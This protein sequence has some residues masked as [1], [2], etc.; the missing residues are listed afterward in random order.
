MLSYAIGVADPT[1][2]SVDCHGTERV[3]EAAIEDAVM[4]VFDL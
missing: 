2:V 3:E 4:E 1:A